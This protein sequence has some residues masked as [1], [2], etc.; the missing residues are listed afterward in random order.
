MS[1]QLPPQPGQ[2]V[3]GRSNPWGP[4]AQDQGSVDPGT[5]RAWPTDRCMVTVGF[6]VLERCGRPAQGACPQCGRGVCPVHLARGPQGVPVCQACA[7]E[8]DQRA[9]AAT[10]ADWAARYRRRYREG[11]SRRFGDDRMAYSFNRY[12]QHYVGSST[13]T[14][15]DDHDHD[16]DI[17][18]S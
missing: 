15:W 14:H 8:A 9:P 6:Y 13:H 7:A 4:P 12:D 1:D 10:D 3:P 11:A 5:G 2:P 17:Y 16:A 18:D